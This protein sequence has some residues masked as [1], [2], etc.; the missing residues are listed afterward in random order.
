LKTK[1]HKINY[2]FIIMAITTKSVWISKN[3]TSTENPVILDTKTFNSGTTTIS[4]T[5]MSTASM[6]TATTSSATTSTSTTT[7]S[8]AT[9]TTSSATT[10]T[11]LATTTTSSSI[12]NETNNFSNA[13]YQ[14]Y[15]LEYQGLEFYLLVVFLFSECWIVLKRLF[16]FTNTGSPKTIR[17]E[18]VHFLNIHRFCLLLP[19]IIILSFYHFIHF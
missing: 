15:A 12:T 10:N 4:T 17:D 16:F 11:S 7:T 5:T 14:A 19:F 18:V 9:T 8:S 13:V 3:S 2:I 1:N 6:N